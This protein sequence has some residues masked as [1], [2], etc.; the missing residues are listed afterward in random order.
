MPHTILLASG[1]NDICSTTEI[2][3]VYL[4]MLI[5]Q[6]CSIDHIVYCKFLNFQKS[7]SNLS[8]D[9]QQTGIEEEIESDSDKIISDDSD[10]KVGVYEK[11]EDWVAMDKEINEED[12]MT[13]SEDEQMNEPS[14]CD[15]RSVY[16]TT[17]IINRE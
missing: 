11:D 9:S 13:A 12:Y 10:K 17:M 1:E 15:I 8:E 5:L 3:N 7:D 2:S 6:C 16:R 14:E 4:W